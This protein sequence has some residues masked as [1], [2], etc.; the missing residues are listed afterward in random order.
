VKALLGVFLIAHGLVH[1]LYF[2][3]ADDLKYPMTAERSWLVTRLGVPLRVVRPV[4]AGLALVG[5]VG[6]VLLA[7]SYWGL[8]V[9][10]SWFPMLAVISAGASLLLVFATWNIQFIF[11]VIINAAILYWALVLGP[12]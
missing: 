12:G 6:F 5:A 2:V 3:P 4:V 7:L 10:T 8:L 9:P 1:L 11:S